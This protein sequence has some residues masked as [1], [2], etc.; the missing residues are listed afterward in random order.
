MSKHNQDERR[1]EHLGSST[2]QEEDQQKE[3][4]PIETSQGV[5]GSKGGFQFPDW[6]T[7]NIS[8]PRSLKVWFR[9]TLISW[10]CLI[11]ILPHDSL[12]VCGQAAFFGMLISFMVPAYMPVSLYVF[13]TTII[14]LGALLGWAWGCAAIAAAHRA[15]DFGRLATQEQGVM[16]SAPGG[17]NI[18]AILE[19]AV[20][21]GEFLDVRSSAVFGVFLLVGVYAMG[22]IQTKYPKLKLGTI[23]FIIVTDICC[24]YGPLIPFGYYTLGEVV[25]IPSTC[26]IAIALAAQFL[27]FPET[28]NTAWTLNLIKVIGL[29]R[30]TL[31]LNEITLKQM[32]HEEHHI[33]EARMEPQIKGSHTGIVALATAMGAQRGFLELE[34]TCSRL[35]G[36]D[37]SQ[38]Y[39]Q[40]RTM[41]VRTFTLDAFF[42]LLERDAKSE[43]G[44]TQGP[45]T[46]GES[47]AVSLISA[48]LCRGKRVYSKH[49]N[50]APPFLLSLALSLLLRS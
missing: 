26:G 29:S 28:L 1:G 48:G 45:V 43:G 9:C 16:M 37:L 30:K 8:N 21:H 49:T 36:K 31:Q 17:A 3:K 33:V 13:A 6:I 14:L 19:A 2:S 44:E 27:I 23:F 12:K 15:R 24:S 32:L 39:I 20:F 10:S 35:S 7:S 11:L 38:L 50:C 34:I 18:E 25:I 5:K 47:H 22:H 42:H 41:I 40:V 46:L 4:T